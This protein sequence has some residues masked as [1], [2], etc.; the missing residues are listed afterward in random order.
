MNPDLS[1]EIVKA[2]AIQFSPVMGAFAVGDHEF[3]VRGVRGNELLITTTQS[4]P[5]R[6]ETEEVTYR[7][8]VEATDPQMFV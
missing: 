8:K 2:L 1:D 5:D 3:R 6:E 7:I 4:I